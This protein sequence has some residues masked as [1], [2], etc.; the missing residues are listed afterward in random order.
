M[1]I[2]SLKIGAHHYTV[3]PDVV[4]LSEEGD[5]AHHDGRRRAIAVETRERPASAIA[6]DLLHEIVHA[7]LLDAGA[8]LERDDEERVCT[9]LGPR[10]A[11]FM[12]DNKTAVHELLDMLARR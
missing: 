2:K 10:L 6:E 1:K 3:T 4:E 11:A 7:L 12:A 8:D 9:V 5:W